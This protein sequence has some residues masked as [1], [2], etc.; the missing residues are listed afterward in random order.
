MG[1]GLKISLKDIPEP[2]NPSQHSFS[3]QEKEIIDS[4]INKLLK[5][6]IIVPTNINEDDFVS[7]IFTRNKKDGSHRMILNLKKKNL[8]Y[9]LIVLILR[10]SLSETLLVWFIKESGWHQ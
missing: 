1:D 6:K 7:S 4:E 2:V 10:W 3:S 5:K 8:I 9:L